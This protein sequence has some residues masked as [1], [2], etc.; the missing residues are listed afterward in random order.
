MKKITLI[1]LSIVL[2]LNLSAQGFRN[3]VLPGF[4]ADPS[5]CCVGDDYYLV[6][7]TFQYFPGVPVFHSKD[8]IHWEQIGHCLTRD[9]QVD[10]T[11]AYSNNTGI[12]A[13][14][15][16]YNDGI[17]YMVTTNVSTNTHFYVYTDDPA[18]EWSEPINIEFARGGCDPSFFFDEDGKC[19]FMWSGD[20]LS[21]CEID[22]KTGKKLSDI[23]RLWQGEGG[24]YHEGPHIYKKDGYYYL[25]IAEGGTEHGH[26]VTIARS[27]FI[28]GPWE[29]CPSNP[30][31]SHFNAKMQNSSIQGL[32]HSDLIQAHDGSWWIVFLGYRTHGYL[33][34]VMGRETF[35]A[36]VRWDEGA[37]P[38]V[39]RTGTIEIDMECETLPQ[40]PMPQE[41]PKEDF[42]GK[43][44]PMGWFHIC[45][46]IR[47]N[48]SFST[49]RP[50]YLRMRP[51]TASLDELGTPTAIAR[52]QT[53]HNFEATALID[54]KSLKSGACAGLSAYYVYWA[55]YDVQVAVKNG[56]RYIQAVSRLGQSDHVMA[57]VPVS[58]SQVYLRISGDE[59]FYYMSYS[60]DGKNFTTLAKMD[61]RFLSSETNGGFTGVML[62]LF[63]EADK[64]NAGYVDVDWF[65]YETQL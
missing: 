65:E 45:N 54:I 46:P 53:E 32:G 21:I 61:Y 19:Y 48:Y 22:I 40:V 25:L 64:A 7:S 16:R 29:P 10:L 18:G 58:K 39:N 12:Y 49:E 44:L 50:G 30:I 38:V 20:Y 37:W 34:H 62:G 23:H 42:D 47:D 51:S 52:K 55:H 36:P 6:N 24:R 1:C 35:L 13:P 14:T 31:L 27:P 26:H 5:V 11:G 56:R 63:T 2:A 28:Y 59:S 41:P 15:I 8:L 60:L 33:Q 17:F 4:H 43:E 9:S 57:E 3:P